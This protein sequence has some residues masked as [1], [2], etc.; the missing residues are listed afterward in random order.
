[1]FRKKLGGFH[2]RVKECYDTLCSLLQNIVQNQEGGISLDALSI[3][4]NT[5]ELGRNE[6]QSNPLWSCADYATLR[7]YTC[8]DG[9]VRLFWGGY[10]R[11]RTF[12]I[13]PDG[14]IAIVY[15]IPNSNNVYHQEFRW[16]DR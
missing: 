4:P 10:D 8:M 14:N 9:E 7:T 3:V 6:I 16:L 12:Q 2:L 5:R 13:H 11:C 1:M 15:A